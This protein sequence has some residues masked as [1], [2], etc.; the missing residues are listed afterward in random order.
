MSS[1]GKEKDQKSSDEEQGEK[2]DL[3]RGALII[4][5]DAFVTATDEEQDQNANARSETLESIEAVEAIE[6]ARSY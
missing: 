3:K 5:D 6:V 1:Y 2:F 4:V